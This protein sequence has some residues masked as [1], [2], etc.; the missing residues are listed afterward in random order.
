MDQ[1]SFIGGYA[2]LFAWSSPARGIAMETLR[3]RKVGASPGG[4]GKGMRL[5]DAKLTDTADSR[6]PTLPYI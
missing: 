6:D 2:G 4:F 1:S 5:A 3:R